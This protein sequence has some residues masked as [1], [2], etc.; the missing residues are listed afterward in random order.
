MGYTEAELLGL[1]PSRR[2]LLA[3]LTAFGVAVSNQELD[4]VAEPLLYRAEADHLW[5]RLQV[6]AILAEA[7]VEDAVLAARYRTNPEYELTV[8]HLIVLSERFE[9]DDARAAARERAGRALERVRAGEPF[10]Q[11]AAQVSEEPGA[12]ERQGLLEP[13]RRGAWVDDFWNAASALEV[14]EVSGVVETQYGFHVLRL[15]GRDT[16]PFSE[17]RSRVAAEVARSIGQVEPSAARAPL[18]EGFEPAD[19]LDALTDEAA[20]AATYASPDGGPRRSVTLA[21]LLDWA[22]TM[23]PA[24]W[25]ATRLGEDGARGVVLGSVVRADAVG[26]RAAA[27]GLTPDPGALQEALE[28]WR[29][30]AAQWASILGF[31]A[32]MGAEAVK[33]GALDALG[34]S[35]QMVE[36][37]RNDVHRIRGLL[38]RRYGRE[39]DGRPGETGGPSGS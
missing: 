16:V 29:A 37:A 5:E 6:E 34:R 22:A 8:R 4:G 39:A 21:E 20:V 17:V 2:D 26:A 3:S 30:D 12:A 24:T 13:G 32:G 18:P 38:E 35:T 28:T 25:S 1:S 11:V 14:G 33:A 15:E 19:D 31:S 23:D 9:S 27:R 10:P 36:L 7:Q